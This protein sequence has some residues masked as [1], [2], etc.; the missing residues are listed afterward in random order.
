MK[1]DG[2][3]LPVRE[4]IK[5]YIEDDRTSRVVAWDG[6]LDVRPEF[7]REFVYGEKQQEA[8]INTV[9]QGFP[10]NIMYFVDRLDG[11]FEVLDGQQRIISI[12][13][14][15]LNQYSVKIPTATGG[16][17]TVN[18]PNLYNE[19][20]D[21]FLDYELHIYICQGTD[22]EKLDWFQ[23]INIA[24]E[25]LEAQEIRNALYHGPW[26]TDAKSAFS[27]RNCAAHKN[28]GKYMAG[29]YIRQKYLETAFLWKAAQ[30]GYTGRDAIASY[31]KVHRMDADANELW[32]YFE[33]V[34]QWVRTN[35]GKDVNKFMKGVPWGLLYNEHKD[36][37]LDPAELQRRVQELMGDEEVQK[38]SGIYTYLLTGEEKYLSPR[39]FDRDVAMSKYQQ[40][41][42]L[43][44]ICKKPFA[45]KDMHADHI[46]PW[47]KGGRTVPDNCQMLCIPCNE[48]KKAH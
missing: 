47:S 10:L 18:Y 1:I 28:Y 44:N 16:Y 9:L 8:V 32:A 11:T 46:I 13:R 20:R 45:F 30:E 3:K 41:G 15:A 40:Q 12:C 43:C 31:M 4:L 17:D 6:N 42:G 2:I 29:D 19:L 23:I 37:M 7:Q 26:L 24:G 21:K 27:R 5:G 25:T 35:F 48:T 14:Y 39:Q 33:A 36:D 34:F 22:K 38:K